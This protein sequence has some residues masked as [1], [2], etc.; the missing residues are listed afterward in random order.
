MVSEEL[1]S[2]VTHTYPEKGS[3]IDHSE[4]PVFKKYLSPSHTKP[5][6]LHLL[7]YFASNTTN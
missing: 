5:L 1:H 7:F 2:Q 3:G 6:I 4:N